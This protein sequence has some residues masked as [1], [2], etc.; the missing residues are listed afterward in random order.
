MIVPEVAAWSDVGRSR[1]INEDRVFFQILASSDADPVAMC[2]VADG[3]GGHL[4]GEVA[5][6]WAVETLKRELADLFEPTDPRQTMQLSGSELKALLEEARGSLSPS[7][8]VLVRKL[9][10]A[11]ENAN[12]AVRQYTLHRPQEA[13]GAGSTLAMSLVKGKRAFVANVGDSRTYLLRQG[14][15]V[16]LTKDHSVVAE[17]I[18]AG[19]LTAEEAY[20]HPQAGLITRC[21]GY[22]DRVEVDIEVYSLR[23]GDC[24]LLCT[25]GLWETLREPAL[26]A[27]IIESAPSLD[28]A[29]RRLTEAANHAGGHD[30]ITVAMLRIVEQS[31]IPT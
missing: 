4:A 10:T 15:L 14:R 21:L 9:R 29:A 2:I 16:Q 7:D 17:L 30:N 1:E 22:L 27:R 3:M 20:A 19:H 26:M 5:S 6:H 25:D 24:L 8:V 11:I 28:I 23:S 18:A 13:M 12:A 31:D